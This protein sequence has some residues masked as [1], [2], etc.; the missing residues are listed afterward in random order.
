MFSLFGVFRSYATHIYG[1]D[2]V[3]EHLGN[4]IYQVTL[5]V[6]RDCDPSTNVNGTGF[7][8]IVS[9]GIF[10]GGNNSFVQELS[11]P[12]SNSDIET[13]DLSL[14]NPCFTVP[15]N[16]CVERAVY[17]AS[18]T[19]PFSAS[20]YVLTYQR[21]CRNL[22]IDNLNQ[23]QQNLSGM[24]LTTQIP[25]TALVSVQ[26]SSPAFVSTPPTALCL[27]APFIYSSEAIDPDGD[28]LVYSF[29]TP[30]D[31]ADQNNPAPAPPAAP[32]YN[33]SRSLAAKNPD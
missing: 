16:V 15:P 5:T 32:P 33:T 31:G 30:L 29:C 14:Q 6:Y 20:G 22:S 19:L 12:L 3:Y 23:S 13:L 9:I 27:N 11:I 26:N 25:G 1:G 18:V 10:S 24:T 7:D 28:Q 4:N 21:C 17:Q 2:L 8:P